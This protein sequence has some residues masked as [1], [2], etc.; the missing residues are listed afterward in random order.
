MLMGMFEQSQHLPD[1]VVH[2]G[3][4][5]HLSGTIE[6]LNSS[7]RVA[8]LG[9]CG[10]YQNISRVLDQ[11]ADAQIVSSKQI[12]TFTVNNVLLKDLSDMLR[13]GKNLN[14]QELW[15]ELDKKLSANA[16][17]A[18]YIPPY[19]NLGMRFIKAFQQI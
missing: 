14:W 10:G 16:R 1:L 4:S 3:H 7:T 12:G 8:V 5:Y 18:D 15:M 19:K 17:W 9:S 11:A 2:R 6:L 13:E